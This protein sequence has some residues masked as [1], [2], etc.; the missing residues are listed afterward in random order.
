MTFL[1][2]FLVGGAICTVGQILLAKT[3]LTTGRILALFVVLGVVL[4]AVGLYEPLIEF[5]EA[6]ASVPLTGFGYSL[7]KGVEQAVDQFGPLGI[8]SGGIAATAAGV[9]AAIVFGYLNAV[10]FDPKTKK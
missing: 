8:F 2:V 10:L 5:A 4:T 9:A 1:K 6:G 7:A 3:M